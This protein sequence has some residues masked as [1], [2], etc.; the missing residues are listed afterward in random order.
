MRKGNDKLSR[1]H[2][3]LIA[4]LMMTK[5]EVTDFPVVP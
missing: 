3:N 1:I 4:G 2:P 5:V